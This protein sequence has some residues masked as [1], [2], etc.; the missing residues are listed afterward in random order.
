MAYPLL[1]RDFCRHGHAIFITLWVYHPT[2]PCP[3]IS[4]K[5]MVEMTSQVGEAESLTDI[6]GKRANSY[7]N[8]CMIPN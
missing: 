3:T 5:D 7:H 2:S 8:L 1:L 6:G 4:P